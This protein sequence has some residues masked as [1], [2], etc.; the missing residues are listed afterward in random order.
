VGIGPQL[1]LVASKSAIQKVI[2]EEDLIKSP[3]YTTGR[4]DP[5]ITNLITER[6]KI[7]YKQKVYISGILFMFL[8][9]PNYM[10]ETLIITWI[11]NQLPKRTRTF[12]AE[13]CPG[14]CGGPRSQMR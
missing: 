4:D 13:M 10:L 14:V 1:V 9:Q 6:D 11:H 5:K 8:T 3:E 2:V 12:D 7:A